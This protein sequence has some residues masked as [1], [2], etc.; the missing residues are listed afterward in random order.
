[1][2]LLLSTR[3]LVTTSKANI[4][5]SGEEKYGKYLDLNTLF[6][7]YINLEG[8]GKTDYLKFLQQFYKFDKVPG[9]RLY[10]KQYKK[11]VAHIQ[12]LVSQLLL[13]VH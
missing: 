2:S 10:S 5:F 9:S 6:E 12:Q 8:F 13:Q 3:N 7:Q 11:Y 4:A 1:M